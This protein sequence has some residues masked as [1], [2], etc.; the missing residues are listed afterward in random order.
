MKMNFENELGAQP[1]LGFWDP[2]YWLEDADQDRF[3]RLRYVEIK[4]GRICML[5]VLGHITQVSTCFTHNTCSSGKMW[6]GT[7]SRDIV[8]FRPIV[9]VV[10]SLCLRFILSCLSF[11]A[12]VPIGCVVSFRC[13]GSTT[14]DMTLPPR[15]IRTRA[16][17][18]HVSVVY[19]YVW[20]VWCAVLEI[21]HRRIDSSLYFI[22]RSMLLFRMR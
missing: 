2:L 16:L 6:S 14:P 15:P 13:L 12:G 18:A 21:I 10:R 1:P 11:L 19:T 5:A 17:Q 22:F 4:H 9:L 8:P 7:R 3:D 20:H